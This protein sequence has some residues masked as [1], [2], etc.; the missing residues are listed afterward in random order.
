VNAPDAGPAGRVAAVDY[1]R[2][3]IGLA[4]SDAL[5]ITTRGLATLTHPGDLAAAAQHV[6]Q[7]LVHE[8]A[9]LVVL[10]LPL[11]ADGRESEMSAEVRRF[12]ERLEPALLAHGAT[13]VLHDEGLTSWEAEEGLKAGG[14]SLEQARRSGAIDQR[15]ALA[16]L[17]GYLR[18]AQGGPPA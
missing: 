15:A 8:G 5:R 9:R 17:R 14:R 2:R 4:V 13:L 7:V 11:H 6:A 18:D 3:R 16:L 12:A 1:G 10:G